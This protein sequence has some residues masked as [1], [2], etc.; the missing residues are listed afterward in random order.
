MAADTAPVPQLTCDD[1]LQPGPRC[2]PAWRTSG[3]CSRAAT[4]RPP[5]PP[6]PR[7]CCPGSGASRS[8]TALSLDTRKAAF[9][10]V[11][12]GTLVPVQP[13]IVM[14]TADG[15]WLISDTLEQTRH[16]SLTEPAR[17][18]RAAMPSSTPGSRTVAP[19]PCP[20]TP[21]A[22]SATC[23]RNRRTGTATCPTTF[24]R[25]TAPARSRPGPVHGDDEVAGSV[26]APSA[27]P[28][29]T[30]RGAVTGFRDGQPGSAVALS[31]LVSTVLR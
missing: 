5:S 21:A 8:A 18:A 14:E 29:D 9:D 19:S 12:T 23:L 3:P 2:R 26:A 10:Q 4:R 25:P 15:S 17:W 16:R 20:C 22:R 13:A 1:L 11:K 24:L 31:D 7:A 30:A 27:R 28:V 6:M